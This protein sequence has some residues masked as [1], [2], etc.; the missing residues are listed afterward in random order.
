MTATVH[1]HHAVQVCLGLSGPVRLRAGPDARWGDYEGAV[2]PSNQPHET[3]V[4]AALLA[5]FWLEP[6]TDEAQRLAPRPQLPILPVDRSKLGE[7]VPRFVA[8]WRARSDAQ[9]AAAV[10]DEVVQILAPTECRE[11]VLDSRVSRAREI[12]HSAPDRRVPIAD[13]AARVSLSPSRLA[14]L[15]RAEMGMP[16][17][18]YL[19]WLR[20]RDA[21]GELT[22]GASITEAAHAA[23]FADAAHLSRTF[24]R[25]LGFTPSTALRVS[26]FVQDMP[27]G[28]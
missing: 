22:R 12:L 1:A 20:L 6:D 15:V 7:I 19:L 13:V 8:C 14:H 4:P 24:R 27:A 18:R 28:R 23:G 11:P 10:L 26:K 21:V 5:T 16:A 17:R 3:D 2:I 9:R 25:M